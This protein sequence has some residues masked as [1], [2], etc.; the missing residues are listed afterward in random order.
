MARA[1]R[2]REDSVRKSNA[3]N[4][5]RWIE[6]AVLPPG[7]SHYWFFE[8]SWNVDGWVFQATAHPEA[9]EPGQDIQ[10]E[11]TELFIHRAGGGSSDK[12]SRTRINITVTNCVD[13]W[14][15]YSL[16]VAAIAP[17][18]KPVIERSRVDRAT[19]ECRARRRHGDE[20]RLICV[21]HDRF[22][23]VK[24]AAL[25]VGA[26]PLKA[27]LRPPRDEFVTQL[28]PSEAMLNELRGNA[29]AISE[30]FQVDVRTGRVLPK[31]NA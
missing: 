15:S 22:G 31:S 30:L 17:S 2:L 1:I 25:P 12:H 6:L 28:K 11:V 3:L 20:D 21:I 10:V 18:M 8:P 9:C 26:Q 24:S 23:N 14:A 29:Q 19:R 13:T 5:S 27:G 7:Q 16:W 4:S